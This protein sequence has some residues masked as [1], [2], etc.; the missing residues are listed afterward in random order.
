MLAYEAMSKQTAIKLH[1]EVGPDHTI[2]LPEEVP[3]G[4]AEVIVLVEENGAA[5]VIDPAGLIGL[6]ADE[7]EVMDEV[8]EHIREHRARWA[9][10]SVG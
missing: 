9:R 3:V 4:P 1:V 8:M 2:R 5:R 7:P 10:R 6:M